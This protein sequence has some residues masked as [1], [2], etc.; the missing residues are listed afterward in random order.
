MLTRSLCTL[1]VLSALSLPV[2]A[3]EPA[4]AANTV[5]NP[6]SVHVL[7]QS[8]GQPAPGITVTLEVKENNTWRMLSKGITDEKGRIPGLFPEKQ[9]FKAGIYRVNFETGAFFKQQKVQT[10]FPEIPV[11]FE[12]K[13]TQTH[14][15]IPL[16]LSPFGY[17]TYRGN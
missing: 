15:H 1:M 7:D 12:V 14:Y 13:A 2:F 10:F 16:L 3:A 8:H 9:T 4:P 11:I 6:L 5:K 17:S